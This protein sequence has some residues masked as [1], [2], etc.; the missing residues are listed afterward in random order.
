M[1]TQTRLKELLHYNPETGV[2]TWL[3]SRG[4]VKKGSIASTRYNN[5]LGMGVDGTTHYA[6]RLA[7]LYME[8]AFPEFEADHINSDK[9]DNRWSNL[10]KATRSQNMRN[11]GV[12]KRS[13][14]CIKG[15]RFIKKRNKWSARIRHHGK[16][17][18]LGVFDT[19]EHA[20]EAYKNAADRY[21]GEF[22]SY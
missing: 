3:E 12:K 14:S 9:I 2:F 22:S 16:Q 15:V 1:I 21:H 19:A 5:Y 7:F 13:T 11:V 18:W 20:S 4:S 17:H 8:G 10:R 6:H